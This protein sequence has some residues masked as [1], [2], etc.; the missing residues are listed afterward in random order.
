LTAAIGAAARSIARLF[1]AR[2]RG[3]CSINERIP[4]TMP[5]DHLSSLQRLGLS[6]AMLQSLLALREQNPGARP[7]RVLVV[8]R[9]TCTVHDG[10]AQLDVRVHPDQASATLAVGD[11]VLLAPDLHGAPWLV[12]RAEPASQIVRRDGDGVRHV[13]VSNVDVAFVVMGLDGDFNPRRAERFIALVHAGGSGIT[14][15]L[16]LT[17]R[18]WAGDAVADDEADAMRTRLGI[19][20]EAVNGLDPATAPRLA[21][22]IAPGQTAVLLGSSGAGKSTL[23][24]TLFGA[25]VEDTGAVRAADDRGKHTTTHRALYLLPHAG[26]CGGCLID[27]PGVRTLRPDVDARALGATFA[28]IEA[29]APQCRFRDCRHRDE[30]GC[31][32]RDAVDADRLSN[33]HK[34]GRELRRDAMTLLERQRQLAEWKARSRG[35]RERMRL[36]RGG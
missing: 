9:A 1:T 35:A 32:V 11:W 13:V 17:K 24:N 33:W 25:G 18:D 20:V 31:A 28:D 14:P 22:Y 19:A 10:A 27:T 36:K 16:V 30:P 23:T 2:R 21:R 15:V 4:D 7:A 5:F 12:A 34:L 29:L 6:P 3:L 8:H 26:S